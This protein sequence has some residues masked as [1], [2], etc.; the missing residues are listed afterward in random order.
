MPRT[1]NAKGLSKKTDAKKTDAKKT[2]ENIQFEVQDTPP[3][4]LKKRGREG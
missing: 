2:D 1:K 4:E 3:P